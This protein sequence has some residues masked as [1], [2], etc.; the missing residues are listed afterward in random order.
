MPMYDKVTAND[1]MQVAKK[2]FTPQTLTVATISPSAEI[3][4]K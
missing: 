4:V 3:A 1:L 2:Y